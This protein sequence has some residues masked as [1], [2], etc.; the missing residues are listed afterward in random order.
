MTIDDGWRDRLERGE[1]EDVTQQRTDESLR[2]NP[3]SIHIVRTRRTVLKARREVLPVGVCDPPVATDL[4]AQVQPLRDAVVL[5]ALMA[6]GE[7]GNP[8][9]P[10]WR[11]K[12]T[13]DGERLEGKSSLDRRTRGAIL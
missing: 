13:F 1:P 10:L 4:V 11:E 5:F 9:Q 7:L 6:C 8:R 2:Q 12:P 3:T